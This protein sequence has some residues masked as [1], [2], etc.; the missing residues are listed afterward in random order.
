LL[1][2]VESVLAMV[3]MELRRLRHDPVE[4]ATRAIQPVLWV[5]V[6][7]VV[8]AHRIS[9]GVQDYVSFIAPGVVFQSATFMALAYGIMMVFERESGILKKLL[10][11]PIPRSSVVIGRSLAGAVRASTQYIIVLASAALVGARFTGNIPLL[12]VGYF[13]VVYTCTGFTALS[14]LIA[15]TVKARE[16]FMG[17]VGA[18]SMPLFFTS[19][20]LYPLDIM[21]EAI[22]LLAMVN[23]LTYAVNALRKLVLFSDVSIL[24]DL[25]ALTL[26]NA[27]SLL[28]AMREL[29][30]I[31]E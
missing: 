20:A 8:M 5:T 12:L 26:F 13:I 7:G 17:I 23:P 18:I 3:E 1:R 25:A 6:F 28:V 2:A 24:E 4:I 30:K 19:N 22:K 15:S 16:R 21:P 9:I 31:I 10:S 14:I 29:D 27:V 11:S